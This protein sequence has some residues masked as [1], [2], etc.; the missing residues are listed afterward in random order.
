MILIIIV[1]VGIW[2]LSFLA[3]RERFYENSRLRFLIIITIQTLL[4]LFLVYY[5]LRIALFRGEFDSPGNI[6]FR[7]S[8]MGLVFA[9][10]VP[11]LLIFL[12]HYAGKLIRIKKKGYLKPLTDLS[13]WISSI[14]ILTI[15]GGTFFG[16]F[17]FTVEKVDIPIK[18]LPKG[19]NGLTIAQISDLHLSCFYKRYG[20]LEKAIEIV[21]SLQPDMIIN[22]GDFVTY[23]A[24]EFGSCDTI[25]AKQ[26]SRFGAFAVLG[27]H[28]M[29]TYMPESSPEWREQNIERLTSLVVNSGY[30][31][32][33]NSNSV[34][35]INRVKVAIAGVTTAGRH[36]D[37]IHGSVSEA[38]AGSD[39]SDFRILLAHDP[40]QWE[41]DVA[42]KT[43]ID[44]TLSGHTHGMQVGI[45]TKAF[46]WS[47][48][49]YF[50]PHWNGLYR[51]G[52]QYHYVNRGLGL[53]A[54][55]FRIWMPPEITL[56]RLTRE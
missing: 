40:N 9:L 23:G 17:N 27:N 31:V 25:L 50:Y 30:V 49:K 24:G 37:I 15:A 3:I 35:D 45:I 41:T 55:P 8:L 26:Q 14:F 52:N 46:R 48:S 53:L 56:I 43:K 18:D 4:N 19:L 36:P 34:I 44:L 5:L 42:G 38:A 10:M 6:W 22:T 33:K 11:E 12:F 28:D 54:I 7:T 29:G 16:R 47:P 13:L 20:K 2:L 21:N 32:L 51:E 1:L 39:S